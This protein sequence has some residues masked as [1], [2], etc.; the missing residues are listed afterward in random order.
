MLK[1]MINFIL[2]F[3][4]IFGSLIAHHPST[5]IQEKM[6]IDDEEFEFDG[7]GDEFH[8]HIGDNIW[9]VTNTIHRDSTGLFADESSLKRAM[10]NGSMEYERKWKC[11]Y[12]HQYWPIGTACQ[13]KD[14]PSKYK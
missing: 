3:S 11:P 14:C 12:C 10:Q 13:N 2:S 6:Y 4:L 9:L 5:C 7:E 8:I 1:S